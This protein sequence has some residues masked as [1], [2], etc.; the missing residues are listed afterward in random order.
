MGALSS[1]FTA[2][3]TDDATIG[4]ADIKGGKIGYGTDGKHVG[5]M[6]AEDPYW[7]NVVFLL[8]CRTVAP[9]WW[10]ASSGG[11]LYGGF[12]TTS[13]KFGN[14]SYYA[15]GSGD[16]LFATLPALGTGDFTIETWLWPITGGA[17]SNYG[18]I[19][20]IG[21]NSTAGGLFLVRNNAP[22]PLSFLCQ[23]C[24]T[25]SYTTLFS[26]GTTIPNT[27]WAHIA[28]VRASGV[29]SFY[30]SGTRVYTGTPSTFNI[31]QT[32]LCLGANNSAAE[33]FNGKF[34]NLRITTAARYSGATLTLPTEEFPTY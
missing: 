1:K 31:T 34:N 30:V 20:Q 6:L 25:S 29:L 28:M 32:L 19:F 24:Y 22:N 7:A 2:Y 13:P 10:Y 21:P 9:F 27:T 17:G 26:P 16:V 4:D 33:S 15:D 11:P 14:V 5:T 3:I 18:R 8:P 23:F 12:D